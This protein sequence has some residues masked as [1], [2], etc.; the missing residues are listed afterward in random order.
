MAIDQKHNCIVYSLKVDVSKRISTLK[1]R[2]SIKWPATLTIGIVV[3]SK[4][5]KPQKPNLS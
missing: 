4:D 5:K 2:L 3:K 1:I